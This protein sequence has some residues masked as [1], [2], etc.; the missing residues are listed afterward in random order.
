MKIIF[1]VLLFLL[2]FYGSAFGVLT[3]EA[4]VDA[5]W[6]ASILPL[7]KTKYPSSTAEE[8]KE[9]RAYAYGGA[10]APDMGFYPFGSTLFTNL[11]HYVRSGD[12]VS[13]LLKD[14]E[15]INRYA[16]AL[17]FLSHYNADEYGHPLA[18]N[19]SVTLVYPKLR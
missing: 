1:V 4:I 13:A 6:E 18:T 14:A 15:N 17:G 9:A 2:P 11:V 10:V 16:F 3:H 12:M 7:L 8:Q 19:K 5:A